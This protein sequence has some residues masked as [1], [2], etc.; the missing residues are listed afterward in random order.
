MLNDNTYD[1]RAFY[2]NDKEE[3]LKMLTADPDAHFTDIGKTVYHPTFSNESIYSGKVSERNP[4]GI[5]GAQWGNDSYILSKDQINNGWDVERT[6]KYMKRA[7]DGFIKIKMPTYKTG[8]DDENV[9]NSIG[10]DYIRHLEN[11]DSIGWNSKT[12]KWTPPTKPGFD[13]N[14]IGIGLDIRKE[15]NPDVYNFLKSTGR[16]QAPYLTEAEERKFREKAY[17]E[18]RAIVDRFYKNTG[19]TPNEKDAAI[20][21]GMAYQ[22]HPMMML[23]KEGSIT[24]SAV[25]KDINQKKEYRRKGV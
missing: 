11:A 13:K 5:V 1:Y 4:K 2:Y 19:I 7:G 12:K 23:N 8:K 17:K 3:A 22:G 10:M 24:R 18:K 9:D 16:L 25:Q 20:L 15:H 14:S 21:T 6:K